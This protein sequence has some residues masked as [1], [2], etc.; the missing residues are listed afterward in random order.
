[1]QIEVIRF[2]KL[3]LREY[4]AT[5]A[6][7]LETAATKKLLDGKIS[8]RVAYAREKLKRSVGVDFNSTV[9]PSATAGR[10]NATTPRT[11]VTKPDTRASRSKLVKAK[12]AGEDVQE[13]VSDVVLVERSGAELRWSTERSRRRRKMKSKNNPRAQK[14]AK[15]GGKGVRSF[16]KAHQICFSSDTDSDSAPNG[17]TRGDDTDPF[18]DTVP[19]IPPPRLKKADEGPNED[20]DSWLKLLKAVP[21]KWLAGV[22]GIKSPK[23]FKEVHHAVF[24]H[25]AYQGQKLLNEAVGEGEV[26]DGTLWA[27]AVKNDSVAYMYFLKKK[28]EWPKL[29]EESVLNSRAMCNSSNESSVRTVR[30]EGSSARMAGLQGHTISHKTHIPS[31]E[32]EDEILP[33][34]ALQDVARSFFLGTLTRNKLVSAPRHERVDSS[35]NVLG[36]KPVPRRQTGRGTY[37]VNR[38]LGLRSI[39]LR[40]RGF[41]TKKNVGKR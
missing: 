34:R 16:L 4:L 9:G 10:G 29:E 23:D 30:N 18:D 5:Q 33:G 12:N 37:Q 17:E 22:D 3:S 36:I 19:E 2:E 21:T 6:A 7:R 41:I 32:E 8:R 26:D 13:V 28:A 11:Q 27:E 24:R 38:S 20:G 31:T 14:K 15:L 39:T 40:S 35:D 1:M 25:A